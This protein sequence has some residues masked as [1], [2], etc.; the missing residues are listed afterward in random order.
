M[1]W[2][3]SVIEKAPLGV[4]VPRTEG[5]EL[6]GGRDVAEPEKGR[7]RGRPTGQAQVSTL[8]PITP[9]D[10]F[11]L[12][13]HSLAEPGNRA[14]DLRQRCAG[15]FGDLPSAQATLNAGEE[16]EEG[17]VEGV[18]AC[19]GSRVYRDATLR[20]LPLAASRLCRPTVPG[21]VGS[22]TLEAESNEVF[23]PCACA[24]TKLFRGQV[25]HE[26]FEY[27]VAHWAGLSHEQRVLATGAVPRSRG[28]GLLH[29]G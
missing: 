14:A 18:A 17:R 23:D 7:S 19:L 15:L 29:L 10:R 11:T 21:T 24:R 16:R 2:S 6:S 5:A 20:R 26:L 1:L 22:P 28:A 3:S 27:S 13:L 9:C 12:G 25:A 8:G 4:G